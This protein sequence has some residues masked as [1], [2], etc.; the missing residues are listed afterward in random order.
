[1][2]ENT[3]NTENIITKDSLVEDTDD[4]DD[5]GS[6][7]KYYLKNRRAIIDRQIKYNKEN[8]EKIKQRQ[9]TEPYR[10][11]NRET[12]RKYYHNIKDNNPE[13]Y[14][15]LMEKT[16]IRGKQYRDKKRQERIDSGQVFQQRIIPEK[17]LTVEEKKERQRNYKKK[18]MESVMNDPEKLKKHRDNNNKRVQKYNKKKKELNNKI[19]D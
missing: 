9:A 1:M 7:K 6:K 12:M 17:Q 16:R 10:Q 8:K 2:L 14:K 3:E 5:I 4:E 15:E 18:Y 19:V 13:K 11:K